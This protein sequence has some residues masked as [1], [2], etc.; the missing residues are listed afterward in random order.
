M[1]VLAVTIGTLRALKR[2]ATLEKSEATTF[3]FERDARAD[4]R[5]G[6]GDPAVAALMLACD[7]ATICA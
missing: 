3:A 6:P 7:V 4:S 2:L 1:W 5:P